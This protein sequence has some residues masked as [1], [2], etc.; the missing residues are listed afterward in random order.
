MRPTGPAPTMPTWVRV[1]SSVIV[2]SIIRSWRAGGPRGRCEA[3]HS[4]GVVLED[5]WPDVVFDLEL[6]EVGEPVVRGDDREVEPEQ[7]LLPQHRACL[8]GSRTRTWRVTSG[9]KPPSRT[10]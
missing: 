10:R 3:E 7:D 8:W 1:I 2:D 4:D 9:F 6:R 5:Q